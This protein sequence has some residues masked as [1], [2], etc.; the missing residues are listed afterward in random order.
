[1]STP[2]LTASNYT[3]LLIQSK[4]DGVCICKN[5]ET[6]E[7]KAF[8][9]K[10]GF[11]P[12][13]LR[14]VILDG[15]NVLTDLKSNP[16]EAR[17]VIDILKLKCE[18]KEAKNQLD[19]AFM[20]VVKLVCDCV[21]NFFSGYG[22]R[23]TLGLADNLITELETVAAPPEQ[24]IQPKT[25]KNNPPNPPSVNPNPAISPP[26]LTISEKKIEEAI[27]S[28][29][30][31]PENCSAEFKEIIFQNVIRIIPDPTASM[32]DLIRNTAE[33]EPKIDLSIPICAQVVLDMFKVGNSDGRD[34]D[35]ANWL[36]KQTTLDRNL[37]NKCIEHFKKD[38]PKNAD[39]LKKLLQICVDRNWDEDGSARQLIATFSEQSTPKKMP[40]A[41]LPIQGNEEKSNTPKSPSKTPKILERYQPPQGELKK[42]PLK[43]E[44]LT[45]N[46]ISYDL[47]NTL[48][49]YRKNPSTCDPQIKKSLFLN[50]KKISSINP[51]FTM[52]GLINLLQGVENPP[53]NLA[54][55]NCAQ[56]VLDTLEFCR[57]VDLPD[58]LAEWLSQRKTLNSKLLIDCLKII[59]KKEKQQLHIS[60]PLLK[61]LLVMYWEKDWNDETIS[62]AIALLFKRCPNF[63]EKNLEN[64]I[65]EVINDKNLSF[66]TFLKWAAVFKYKEDDFSAE[67]G[68]N[69]S[70]HY[71][72]LND[73]IQRSVKE[74]WKLQFSLDNNDQKNAIGFALDYYKGHEKL[75][76]MTPENLLKELFKY[77]ELKLSVGNKL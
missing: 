37:L 32:E 27:D 5:N 66:L 42:E 64:L 43:L 36:S 63:E 48:P 50:I 8:N 35:L 70:I 62:N 55:L 31:D 16:K 22:L 20:R 30:K 12:Q 77:I 11:V 34:K 10:K 41:N 15:Y 56:V 67:K 2:P 68:R 13:S 45:P 73:L 53:I 44:G 61:K 23:S 28:Y 29:I 65:N 74:N 60:V 76:A 18:M 49:E 17:T 57:G 33:L 3:L 47:K 21:R 25:L 54:D 38:K 9:V 19:S 75:G 7:Q 26:S 6:N 24:P 14:D 39:I 52:V 51:C 59:L 58:D 4:S 71:P 72:V 69:L 1:M 40:K 46:K